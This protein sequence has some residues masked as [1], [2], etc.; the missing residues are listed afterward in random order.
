MTSSYEDRLARLQA[1]VT[2]LSEMVLTLGG[3][4]MA[5]EVA[6]TNAVL[7]PGAG[8]N[9]STA[10]LLDIVYASLLTMQVSQEHLDGF[11]KTAEAIRTARD[12]VSAVTG[13]GAAGG[14]QP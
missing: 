6:A 7:D 10:E 13:G 9:L 12:V 14:S 4:C 11:H 8:I 5:L 3:R 2:D 1:Q